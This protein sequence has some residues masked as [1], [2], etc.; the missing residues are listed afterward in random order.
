MIIQVVDNIIRHLMKHLTVRRPNSAFSP[1]S[2][3]PGYACASLCCDR[4]IVR[5]FTLNNC[6]TFVIQ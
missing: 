3:V 2:F 4:K 6:N 5:I 1:W